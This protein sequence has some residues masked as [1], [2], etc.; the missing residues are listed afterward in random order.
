MPADH[1]AAAAALRAY[2]LKLPSATEEFPWGERVV[3]VNQKIFVF[4]GQPEGGGLNISLKLPFSGAR[5]LERPGH[6]PTR[7]G[8]G[9]A[10]WVSI[11]LSPDDEAD[12]EELCTWIAESYR[13]VA[14][15]RL[16][17]AVPA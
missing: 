7:Y 10:G 14:P 1:T 12:V 8:L 3:K 2:A 9:K 11:R 17:A 15:R 13:A 5:A 4:L 6:T 16:A